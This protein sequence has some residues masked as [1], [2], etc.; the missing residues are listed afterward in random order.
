[1]PRLADL[2]ETVRAA[3]AASSVLG[4]AWQ[5]GAG[6]ALGQIIDTILARIAEG[7][8]LGA[9]VYEAF[10]PDNAEGT[11]LDLLCAIVGIVREPASYSTGVC[12]LTG[13]AATVVPAGTLL[14]VPDGP[15]VATDAAVTLTG[16]ADDVD[17]TAVEIGEVEILISSVTEIH[18]PVAGLTSCDNAAAFTTGQEVETDA[19]LRTRREQSLVAPSASTD[20]GIGAALAALTSVDFARAISDRTAHTVRCLVYPN[21]AD[22]DAVAAAIWDSVPAG[23]ELTG[24]QSAVVTDAMGHSQTVL[25]DWV[26]E[27]TI[28][29]VV[30]ISGIDNTPA[31]Q[32]AI[33]TAVL[34]WFDDLEVGGDVYATQ[35]ISTVVAAMG[36]GVTSCTVT[37][38]AGASVSID[39]DE[40]AVTS[41][42]DITVNIV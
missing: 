9:A 20:Y 12:Q 42:G 14:R 41:T 25:W 32:A 26:S 33:K 2:R 16:G 30:N 22:T 29:V 1:V 17:C 40:L 39:D 19:A 31:N 15:I 4:P 34:A 6:A 13:V 37:V 35:I 5:T 7:Y 23:I 10:D 36:S 8:E 3:I 21:T 11:Q 38:D 28:T 24:A 18:T 27:V